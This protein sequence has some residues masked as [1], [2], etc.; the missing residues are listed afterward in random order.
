MAE[1]EVFILVVLVMVVAL[2]APVMIYASRYKRVPPSMA[3]VVY[4]RRQMGSA[5]GYSVI[6]GGAKFV[7]PVM[8]EIAWLRTGVRSVDIPLDDLI[9]DVLRT[10]ARLK[11][12]ATAQVKVRTDPEGLLVAAENLLGKSEEEIAEIAVKTLEGHT[13][14]VCARL[15]VG[16]LA[17]DLEAVA[18][19]A[20]EMAGGDL[21]NMGIE[22]RGYT[23]KIIEDTDGYI[24]KFREATARL[25]ADSV[26]ASVRSDTAR[27]LGG[28]TAEEPATAS[29]AGSSSRRRPSPP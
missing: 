19:K 21:A 10:G 11:A 28:I 29:A 13:R 14:G 6:S 9:T 4:G 15:T 24:A 17:A 7:R 16:Q 1:E 12:L 2:G 27:I 26:T 18:S 3:M 23:L 22:V 8:E 20:R 25:Q 5:R